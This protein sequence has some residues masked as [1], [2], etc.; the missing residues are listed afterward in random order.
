[1]PFMGG[2]GEGKAAAPAWPASR[3]VDILHGAMFRRWRLKR[4]HARYL[5]SSRNLTEGRDYWRR[6]KNP[7]LGLLETLSPIPLL[8]L[9]AEGAQLLAALNFLEENCARSPLTV[10]TVRE[11][12]RLVSPPRDPHAGD[13]RKGQANVVDSRISRPPFQ[14]V[15]ALMMQLGGKLKQDQEALD[16]QTKTTLESAL[17]LAVE[18]HQR[19]A[20]IHPF[21][22][23]NGRVAR[24]AMNHILRRYGQGYVIL[25]PISESPEHFQTLEE[26]H[27]GMVSSFMNFAKGHQYQV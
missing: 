11:Y 9:H 3:W 10:D 1:M 16:R 24:L 7:I 4:I 6:E 21:V 23:G 14:K 20:F 26:A 17:Q 25:P 5:D 15:P 8:A 27:G 18:V 12:H 13:Y 19:V 2:P 22:D